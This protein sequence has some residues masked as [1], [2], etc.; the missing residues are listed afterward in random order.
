MNIIGKTTIHPFFFYS[1][2]VF[3]YIIW[4]NS[5]ILLFGIDIV[6]KQP[7]STLL[8]LSY[9]LFVIALIIIILSLINLGRNTTL[10]LPL[11]NTKFV[12][13]GLY[14]FSRNPTYLGFGLL[15]VA[16]IIFAGSLIVLIAG[17]SSLAIYHFII[18]GEEKFLEKKFGAEYIEYKKKV[19]RYI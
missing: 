4:M 12:T 16:S 10:G 8:F 18:L 6:G 5:L 13:A 1:G 11:Q 17:I 7:N 19:R 3:G 15:T 2:K 9:L 14:R